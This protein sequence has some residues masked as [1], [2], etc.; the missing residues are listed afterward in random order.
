DSLIKNTR[1]TLGEFGKHIPAE[2]IRHINDV[3]AQAEE[4]LSSGDLEIIK[5]NM[6]KVE[7]VA[8]ELANLLMTIA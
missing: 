4:A 7:E 6:A 8:T 2:K 5:Q 3:L 1:R